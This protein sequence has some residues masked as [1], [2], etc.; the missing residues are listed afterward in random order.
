MSAVLLVPRVYISPATV[1]IS[2][3]ALA[4]LGAV[5]AQAG[6]APRL[7]GSLRVTFWGAVAMAATA[8]VGYLFGTSV[9]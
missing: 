1:A 6:G 9:A 2:L 7:K 8:G 3:V 4:I 5:A